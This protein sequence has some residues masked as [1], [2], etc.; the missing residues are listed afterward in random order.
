MNHQTHSPAPLF[1][2]I[3]LLSLLLAPLASAT[4]LVQDQFDGYANNVFLTTPANPPGFGWNGKW[5]TDSS[6]ARSFSSSFFDGSGT[7]PAGDYPA[8][9]GGSINKSGGDGGGNARP[10][11]DLSSNFAEGQSVWFSHLVAVRNF[12]T[13]Q[14]NMGFNYNDPNTF[15]GIGNTTNGI[16]ISIDGT[17]EEMFARV[18][19]TL[20]GTG[21]S[22]PISADGFSV[23]GNNLSYYVV[24]QFNKGSG[25]GNDSLKVW[26]NEGTTLDLNS[27]TL[28]LTGANLA[29]TPNYFSFNSPNDIAIWS[30]EI[31]LASS[32]EDLGLT[33]IPEPSSILLLLT[34]LAGAALLKR[35]RSRR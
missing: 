23:N 6:G 28:S 16:G 29:D 8:T 26:V 35:R 7:Q 32:G 21:L 5:T 11:V 33:V 17:S 22:T 3:C 1:R 9:S 20:S 4:L 2:G 18:N 10:T 12:T 31:N 14:F 15:S 27:P 19:G 24:G 30:D 34:G 13:G 25:T